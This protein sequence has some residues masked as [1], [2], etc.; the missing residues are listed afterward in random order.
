MDHAPPSLLIEAGQGEKQY[1][2][3]LFA[4][5]ELFY[6]FA[7]RDILVRYKQTYLGFLWAFV[8]P[9][10]N[11]AVLTFVFG[12]VAHLSSGEV[13][14]PLFVL[15]GIVPWQLFSG[16]IVDTSQS[17]LNNATMISKIYF[18]RIILPIS[19]VIVQFVDFLVSFGLMLILLGWFGFL[20]HFGV[21]LLPV[22]TLMTLVLSLGTGFW[23]SAISVRFRDFRFIVPFL[24]QFG[25]FLSPVGYSAF[26]LNGAWKWLYFLNPM[27][28]IIE[29]FR[30]AAFGTF[31]ADLPAAVALSCLVNGVIF[32][33][34]FR[35]FRKMERLFGDI[36]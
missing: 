25:I 23:L 33:T 34:G 26:L 20:N 28:G 5:R 1:V 2:K 6:F 29:G 35:F 9:L 10:L 31:H 4:F 14:Y 11:I 19:H 17:L 15:V 27:A 8:R 22:F 13:S 7:W 30:F 3:D 18:P 32:V 16:S 24:I 36:I 12:K 21:L